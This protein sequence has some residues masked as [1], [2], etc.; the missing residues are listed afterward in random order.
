MLTTTL[1]ALPTAS[2]HAQHSS[3]FQL[4]VSRKKGSLAR[5]LITR[6][7]SNWIDCHTTPG[8]LSWTNLVRCLFPHIYWDTSKDTIPYSDRTVHGRPQTLA[9]LGQQGPV[10]H[11]MPLVYHPDHCSLIRDHQLHQ[12]VVCL[13]L[14][15]QPGSPRLPVAGAHV[16]PLEGGGRQLAVTVT[17]LAGGRRGP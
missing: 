2:S 11:D 12:A 14:A 9:L 4:A 3:T 6:D 13:A 17:S 16:T 5:G 7:V 8:K 10:M 1:Q 15:L